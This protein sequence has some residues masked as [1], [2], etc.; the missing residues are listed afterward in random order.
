MLCVEVGSYEWTPSPASLTGWRSVSGMAATLRTYRALYGQRKHRPSN[1][2][3]LFSIVAIPD[4]G[5]IAEM[6]GFVV[7]RVHG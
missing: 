4:E 1:G 7:C 3:L 5:G 6:S 2:L